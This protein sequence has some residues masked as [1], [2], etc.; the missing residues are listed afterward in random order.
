[1]VPG[2]M[3]MLAAGLLVLVLPGVG[4]LGAFSRRTL[5]LPRLLLAV[6]GASSVA[7][8]LG[9]V[10]LANETSPPSPALQTGWVLLVANLGLWA[11]RAPGRIDWGGSGRGAAAV[12]VA[13]FLAASCAGLWL[14]PPLED[15]D[16]EVRGTAWGLLTDRKPWFLT[17]REQWLPMAHPLLFHVQVAQSMV[18]TGEIET[19]RRSYLS[20]QEAARA[21]R[22]GSP[23]DSMARWREDHA[24]FV[25]E[26][27]L[28][29]S[30][31]PSAV[32]AGLSLVLLFELVRRLS[33]SRL[34]AGFACLLYGSAPETVVRAA[35]AGYFAPAVFWMLVAAGLFAP[36]EEDPYGPGLRKVGWFAAAGA[37]LAWT[38]HKTVAFVLGTTA[39]FAWRAFRDAG[40]VSPRALARAV[41]LRAVALGAGF[42]AATLVWWGYGLATDRHAFVDD[43]LRMH[44]LHRA[45][46][47]DVRLG[48]SPERYA[49]G[50]AAVWTE[51]SGHTGWTLLP[52]GLCGFVLWLRRRS[53]ESDAGAVLAAWGLA[54]AVVFSVT[55]WRQTKHLMNA[56]AP[57]VAAAVVFA[58]SARPRGLRAAALAALLVAL[59]WNAATD[60][61]LLRDFRSLTITGAS[62]VDGW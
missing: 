59:A 37:L 29:G 45:L 2:P 19:T 60:A 50:I 12:A 47:D 22:D 25:A 24:A 17:N 58:V 7:S 13:G 26:P 40:S 31:A 34:A 11:F 14:V 27:A 8:L 51:F 4:T 21:A 52:V 39:L 10:L 16:M 46:L 36:A 28:V 5:D 38:D 53:P 32:F 56:L 20:A 6:V 23:F 18:F 15:H 49:P 1:M 9:A 41:D 54:V 3:R 55:D 48:A 57:W 44:V 33:G 42:T 62:D 35:Y 30:R 61:A 43:H